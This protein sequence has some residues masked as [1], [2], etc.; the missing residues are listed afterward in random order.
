MYL[1]AEYSK[2]R[3]NILSGIAAAI[4]AIGMIVVA[5]KASAAQSDD[6]QAK[7]TMAVHIHPELEK[8]AT[9]MARSESGA[10][11][12]GHASHDQPTSTP[13]ET[14]QSELPS[15]RHDAVTHPSNRQL[16]QR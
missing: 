16:H 11:H 6:S 13:P 4:V 8:E 5:G 10:V 9:N 3:A 14:D 1:I 2:R 15:H 7:A 12:A